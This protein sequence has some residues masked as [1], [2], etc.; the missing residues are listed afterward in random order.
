M[1]IDLDQFEVQEDYNELLADVALDLHKLKPTMLVAEYVAVD[2][3]VPGE[4]DYTVNGVHDLYVPI[5][6]DLWF[7]P[8]DN[9]LRAVK[10]VFYI[11][12]PSPDTTPNTPSPMAILAPTPILR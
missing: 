12:S 1:P 10:N 5:E 3:S 8:T 11:P 2:E 9:T 6:G 4:P 7:N